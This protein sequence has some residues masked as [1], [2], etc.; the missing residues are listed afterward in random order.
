MTDSE[1][2]KH[3]PHHQIV[4]NGR[5]LHSCINYILNDCIIFPI[6]A[7]DCEWVTSPDKIRYPVGLLQIASLSKVFLIQLPQIDDV[8]ALDCLN[9][10]LANGH[11][12]K[13][14]VGIINDVHHL[15]TD[16]KFT[17]NGWFD[18]RYMSRLIGSEIFPPRSLQA[19]AR[20]FLGID[21]DKCVDV[22]CSN[23]NA[24]QLSDQ[25]IIYAINDVYIVLIILMKSMQIYNVVYHSKSFAFCNYIRGIYDTNLFNEQFSHT[26]FLQGISPFCN[27]DFF[28]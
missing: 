22:R 28:Q 23:W 11:I 7:M 9:G 16:Y 1:N 17:V 14:G 27:H 15:K 10:L 8:N 6:I 19:I 4:N 25:Q 2:G 26:T 24:E 3:L 5:S 12:I 18:L 13:V 21:V 20:Q